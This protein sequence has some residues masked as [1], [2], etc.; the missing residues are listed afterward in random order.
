MLVHAV[1][2]KEKPIFWQ[3]EEMEEWLEKEVLKVQH[4]KRVKGGDA[5]K[6]EWQYNHIVLGFGLENENWNNTIENTAFI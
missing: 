5:S 6:W 3:E 4:H 2:G 1:I